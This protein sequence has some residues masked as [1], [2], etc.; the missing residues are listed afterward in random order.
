MG[1]GEV[2]RGKY[3]GGGEKEMK[4]KWLAGREKELHVN[5]STIFQVLI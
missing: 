5:T 3:G 4:W 2:V 1:N